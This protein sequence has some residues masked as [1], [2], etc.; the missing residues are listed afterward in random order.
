[1]AGIRPCDDVNRP[2]AESADERHQIV[3]MRLHA[4]GRP[5]LTPGL[6]AEVA[7][8]VG[9]GAIAIGCQR[10]TLPVPGAVVR[11]G[12]MHEHHRFTPALLGVRQARAVHV[13]GLDHC[14]GLDC[15]RL[16]GCG[17]AAGQHG[18]AGG[19]DDGNVQVVEQRLHHVSSA[20]RLRS[21][22]A[23]KAA[24]ALR[25]GPVVT[26]PRPRFQAK[27]SGRNSVTSVIK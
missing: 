8:R 10:G 19:T 22:R 20:F 3:R 5:V 4:E 2:G 17:L 24:P 7:L 12:P 25:H 9:D 26:H 21:P 14:C 6:G 13:H 18:R 15:R 1:M 23:S 27:A 16:A 11:D